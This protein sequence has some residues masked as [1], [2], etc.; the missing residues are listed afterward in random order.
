[1]GF[2]LLGETEKVEDLAMM[3]GYVAEEEKGPPLPRIKRQL[4]MRVEKIIDFRHAP[5]SDKEG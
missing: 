4:T 2:Q 5:H 3:D 1:L